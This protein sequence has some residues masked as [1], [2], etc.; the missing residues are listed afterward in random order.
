M[1]GLISAVC[2]AGD[3]TCAAGSIPYVAAALVVVAAAAAALASA[4]APAGAL[5]SAPAGT[6]ALLLLLRLKGGMVHG[7]GVVRSLAG[8]QAVFP[9]LIDASGTLVFVMCCS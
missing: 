3:L 5:A 4:P 8:Q 7:W 2:F 6:L 1:S 9:W